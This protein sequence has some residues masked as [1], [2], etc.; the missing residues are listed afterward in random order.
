M[1]NHAIPILYF[2]TFFPTLQPENHL[3][4]PCVE[5]HIEK[6]QN[7]G[8][9]IAPWSFSGPRDTRSPADLVEGPRVAGAG[10]SARSRP[11][12]P[13]KGAKVIGEKKWC[14]LVMGNPWKSP[15]Y[16]WRKKWSFRAGKIMENIWKIYGEE[17]GT[18]G[19]SPVTKVQIIEV[20]GRCSI[21]TSMVSTSINKEIDVIATSISMSIHPL[22]IPLC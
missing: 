1:H 2:S 10:R 15:V 8:L 19:K 9:S 4:S 7:G 20:N 11:S 17:V 5:E 12:L 18:Y 3:K 16:L 6:H 13:Q 22:S 14:E 21:D